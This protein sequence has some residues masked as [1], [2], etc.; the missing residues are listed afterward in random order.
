MLKFKSIKR[1]YKHDNQYNSFIITSFYLDNLKK[2]AFT[3]SE[4]LFSLPPLL[5]QRKNFDSPNISFKKQACIC[6]K[7]RFA[8]K[9]PVDRPSRQA[10]TW[11]LKLK[12]WL[13][14]WHT[15]FI[16]PDMKDEYAFCS[17][18]AQSNTPDLQN[19]YLPCVW[20]LEPC[21]LHFRNISR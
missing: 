6:F 10:N 15:L 7:K 14:F 21:L 5:G 16:S 2:L 12:R 1:E 18:Q 20:L 3:F 13:Y 4:A 11:K 9:E 19:P 8:S 17:S